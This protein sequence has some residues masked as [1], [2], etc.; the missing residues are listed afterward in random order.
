MQKGIIEEG[1]SGGGVSIFSRKKDHQKEESG[2]MGG[3][4]YRDFPP[5]KDF[6][7]GES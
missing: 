2:R 6:Q 3:K 4:R 5:S 1:E 7:R